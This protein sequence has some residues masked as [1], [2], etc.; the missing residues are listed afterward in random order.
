[1]FN[2]LDVDINTNDSVFDLDAVITLKF[3]IYS[4]MKIWKHPTS[5]SGMRE[6]NF[7]EVPRSPLSNLLPINIFSIRYSI[8]VLL[9]S[10]EE[11]CVGGI[12]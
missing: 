7:V 3:F 2:D 12:R 6:R 8:H 5:D 9:L 11:Y 10:S 4:C 1:M